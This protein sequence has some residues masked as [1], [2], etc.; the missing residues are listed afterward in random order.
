MS[1]N[2]TEMDILDERLTEVANSQHKDVESRPSDQI[3]L[4]SETTFDEN[5]RE[6]KISKFTSNPSE[7]TLDDHMKSEIKASNIDDLKLHSVMNP[8]SKK[9]SQ[10]YQLAS[11]NE[12]ESVI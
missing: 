12:D 6:S 5:P 3:G 1:D 10:R 7:V 2:D 9:E 8:C 11:S 4:L